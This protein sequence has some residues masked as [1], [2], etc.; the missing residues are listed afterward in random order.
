MAFT[1]P[2]PT[3]QVINDL[4]DSEKPVLNTNL[5]ELSNLTSTEQELFNES[6]KTIEPEKRK[7]I[8]N[9]LVELADDNIELNFDSIFKYCLK[10]SEEAVRSLAIEGLWENEESSLIEPLVKLLEQ[11]SSEEVQAAAATALGKFTLMVE[12]DRLRPEYKDRLQK[13][14]LGIINDN[15]KNVDVRRRALES[16][17]PLSIPQVK[18]VISEAYQSPVPELKISSIYAMGKSCDPYWMPTVLKELNNPEA[19]VR[20]EAAGACRELEDEA[21]VP[22]LIKLIDD[23]DSD[24]QMAAI[25]ALGEIGNT[26]ARESLTQCLESEDEVVRQMAEQVLKDM[27]SKED[28]LSFRR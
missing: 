25:Q 2:L 16:I 5:A 14:L 23:F 8:I 24:V 21:A 6:W 7:Q 18:K 13:T 28:P 12:H 20:Y 1:E 11:D 17:S 15:K 19:E 26:E 27:Q 3:E 22:G 10:D 4:A 9:R